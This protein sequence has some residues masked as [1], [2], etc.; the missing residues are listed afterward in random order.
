MKQDLV[1]F[2]GADGSGKSTLYQAFRRATDYQILCIDRWIG[3]Q[4][5]YDH[6]YGR[7]DKMPIWIEE[8]VKL[9]D[10]YQVFLIVCWAPNE[11][12]KNRLAVK[13]DTIAL[14]GD[15][16][17]KA[18]AGFEVY[19]RNSYFRHKLLVDTTSTIDEC[20]K[21]ILELINKAPKED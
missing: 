14:V 10:L 13:A 7:P 5:V 15:Q 21:A 20:L 3:S 8:E 12:L 19:A 1:V 9:R 17:A 2:E 18:N 11:V 4:I 16:Y 6:I